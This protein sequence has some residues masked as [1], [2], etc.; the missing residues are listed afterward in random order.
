MGKWAPPAFFVLFQVPER[1]RFPG[2]AWDSIHSRV[3]D[4]R[5]ETVEV[6]AARVIAPILEREQVELVDVE[7]KSENGRWVLRLTIDR[8]EGVRLADC[9]SISHQAGD[10]I[11]VEELIP[12]RYCLEVSSPGL[13]RVLKKEC[14]FQRFCGSIARVTLQEPLAGRRNFKGK[15][16]H[17][18]NGLL[19]LED[20]QGLLCRLPLAGVKKA[21]L[22]AEIPIQNRKGVP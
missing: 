22:A 12:H 16:L 9:A 18:E 17:C 6:Q 4:M 11:E 19:D 7:F 13:D 21:R 3:R 10:L 8:P 5:R 15:I 2:A 1:D 20:E 14:H